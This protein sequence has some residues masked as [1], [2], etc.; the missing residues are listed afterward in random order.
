VTAFAA[1]SRYI[2]GANSSPDAKP[3]PYGAF[4]V[5]R[6]Q[7]P[8]P[9]CAHLQVEPPGLLLML[10]STHPFQSRLAVSLPHEQAPSNRAES[11]SSAVLVRDL[12]VGHPNPA[13]GRNR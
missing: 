11:S 12:P 13:R 10:A 8:Q 9:T 4:F 3:R 1:D 7:L 2:G 6:R 5:K